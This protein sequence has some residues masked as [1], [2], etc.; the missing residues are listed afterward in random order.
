MDPRRTRKAGEAVIIWVNGAF[1]VGKTQTAAELCRRLVRAKVQD[2][3][4]PGYFLR[5]WVGPLEGVTDF[6]QMSLWRTVVAEGLALADTGGLIVAPMTI[7]DPMVYDKTIGALKDQGHRV[8]HVVL[9][10]SKATVE[11]RLRRRGDARSWNFAQVDRCLDGLWRLPADLRLDTD[12]LGLDEVVEALAA[13]AGLSLVR[14][15]Q[16]RVVAWARRWRVT[17]AHLR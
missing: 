15:R 11:Q 17:L 9:D 12:Q 5:R 7:V 16:S 1:G 2:P 8:Y 4:Q 13:G 6:Q 3:E 14:G 10:A